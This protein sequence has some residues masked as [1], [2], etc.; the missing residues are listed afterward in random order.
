MDKGRFRTYL[1]NALLNYCSN[2]IESARAQ[3][4][5]GGI[6]AASLE[7][8]DADG[9]PIKEVSGGTS[10]SDAYDK[11]WAE[12]LIQRSLT[13]LETEWAGKKNRYDNLLPHLMKDAGDEAYVEVG[14]CRAR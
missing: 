3:K 14:T 5:G 6:P 2:E 11:Q 9:R 8:T 4:R 1:L 12:D 10:P 7:E 13:R